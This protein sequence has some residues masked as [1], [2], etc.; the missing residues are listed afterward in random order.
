MSPLDV[1]VLAAVMVYDAECDDIEDE[2]MEE[3]VFYES[4]MIHSMSDAAVKRFDEI[5]V[6]DKKENDDGDEVK[7]DVKEED[8]SQDVE[9]EKEKEDP[10][11]VEKEDNNNNEDKQIEDEIVDKPIDKEQEIEK[12]DVG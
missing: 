10:N 3:T 6:G 11:K 5:C 7:E 2:K 9:K 12:E 1:R 8:E 4:A